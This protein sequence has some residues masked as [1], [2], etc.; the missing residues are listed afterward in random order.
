MTTPRASCSRG[1]CVVSR[2]REALLVL[3]RRYR[4]RRRGLLVGGIGDAERI[5]VRL[6]CGRRGGGGRLTRGHAAADGRGLVAADLRGEDQHLDAAVLLL[7]ALAG[8]AGNRTLLCV[9]GDGQ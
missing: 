7:A 6:G 9:A 3:R 8:V 5:L 1:A 4:G 2:G